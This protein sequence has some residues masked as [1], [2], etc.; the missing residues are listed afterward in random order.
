MMFMV[1]KHG[2]SDSCTDTR[3]LYKRSTRSRSADF[4]TEGDVRH[5]VYLSTDGSPAV[6]QTIR[7]L[8]VN[9][10]LCIQH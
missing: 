3:S 2:Q 5:F 4:V 9:S 6:N 8:H 1:D 10:L 7:V